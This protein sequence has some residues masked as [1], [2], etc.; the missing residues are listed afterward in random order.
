MIHVW[1]PPACGKTLFV[2]MLAAE[3]V[4]RGYIHWLVLDGKT[5]HFARLKKMIEKRG[6]ESSSV[7]V[8]VADNAADARKLVMESTQR[9]NEDTALVVVDP[10][11]RVLDMSRRDEIMWGRE[12]FEEALPTLAGIA[13]ARDV[14]VAMT[15]EVRESDIGHR[16]VYHDIL[17][18]WTDC[19]LRLSRDMS[20]NVTHV[21]KA[22]NGADGEY[23]VGKMI[24]QTDDT[25]R[26]VKTDRRRVKKRCSVHQF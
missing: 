7:T 24:L 25:A 26:F 14:I 10:I 5:S 2:S 23:H 18:S 16:A 22:F 15:S 4:D 9:M 11:T 17:K 20:S 8:R 1:G 21:Y 19:D 6:R 13:H 3:S 12:L